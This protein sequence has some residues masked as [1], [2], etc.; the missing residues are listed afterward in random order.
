M[1]RTDGYEP[2]QTLEAFREPGGEIKETIAEAERLK[3]P[4]QK[5][6]SSPFC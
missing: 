5:H 6:F 1:P 2:K 4:I 3:D